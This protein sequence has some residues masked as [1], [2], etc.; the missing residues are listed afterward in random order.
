M[1]NLGVMLYSC[2]PTYQLFSWS[3]DASVR[4]LNKHLYYSDDGQ[5]TRTKVVF[6]MQVNLN[7]AKGLSKATKVTWAPTVGNKQCIKLLF[8][9]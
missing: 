6:V 7:K 5:S 3:T 2:V 1:A 9:S 4:I 8:L